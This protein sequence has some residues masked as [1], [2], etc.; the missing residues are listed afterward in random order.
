MTYNYSS[1]TFSIKDLKNLQKKS[2]NGDAES[3]YL[4]AN[5]YESGLSIDNEVQIKPNNKKAFHLIKIAFENGNNEAIIHYANYL[6]DKKFSESNIELGIEL[7]KRAISNNDSLGALNLAKHY[8]KEGNYKKAFKYYL[9][10]EALGGYF[11]F[12]IGISY[13][14]GIGTKQ[15]I[16]TAIKY[17]KSIFKNENWYSEYEFEEANYII[18][19]LYLEGIYLKKSISK[20]IRHFETANRE[21]DHR[22]AQDIL[23]ILEGNEK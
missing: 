16:K 12:E 18:G 6:T 3:Q 1:E 17:F 21:N 13:Y 15:D 10:A 4:L 20:A 8:S 9:L 7:Y 14:F 19:R 2:K 22:S 23:M 5:Y 11:A